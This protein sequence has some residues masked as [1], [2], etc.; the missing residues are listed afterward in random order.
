MVSNT[1]GA[2]LQ[3]V[4]QQPPAIRPEGKVTEQVNLISDVVQGLTSRPALVDHALITD[5]P[6]GL[7]FFDTEIGST[8]FLVGHKAGYLNVWELDGTSY[9]VTYED[10]DA[11]AYLGADVRGYVY[12]D[13][14]YVTDRDTTVAVDPTP[15]TD[16]ISPFTGVAL[17]LGGIYSRTY[18][19]TIRYADDTTAVGSYTT[20]DGTGTGDA[21]NTASPAIMD[22]IHTAI[23]AE[24]GWKSGSAATLHEGY[25]LFK[26][27]STFTLEVTDGDADVSIR[28]HTDRVDNVAGLSAIAPHG[29]LV[30]V[31]GSDEGTADDYWLR[32]N[33]DSTDTVGAGWP[34]A[35]VW[36]EWF[37]VSEPASFDLT[38]MPHVLRKDGDAFVLERG[39]WFARRTGDAETNPFPDFV[40][41]SIRDIGGFQSRLVFAAGPWACMTRTNEGEDFF[42]KSALT[43]LAD[44]P[45]GMSSTKE[46]SVRLDWIIPFDRDLVF[47][48]DP[49]AGQFIVAG[50]DKLTPSNASIVQ[51][52]AFEMRGGAKPVQTGRTIVFPYKAGTFSGIKE[53]YTNDDVTTNGAQTLTETLDRYIVGLVDHMACST[54]LSTILF[55]TD[56]TDA[57]STLWVYKYLWQGSD[58]V[59]SSWC[60]WE[61]PA[62][63]V[64]FFF[65]GSRVF[66]VLYH[67]DTNDYSFN[68]LDLDIPN[69]AVT[70]YPVCLDRRRDVVVGAGTV[71]LPFPNAR[72]AQS[73]DCLNIGSEAEADQTE[74]GADWVY[75][76]DTTLI[77]NGSTLI[78]G[79]KYKRYVEPTMP[80]L[81]DRNGA[82]VSQAHVVIGAFYI[83]YENVGALDT[84]MSSPYRDD[85]EY[86]VNFFEL[87][88]DPLISGVGMRSGTLEV[89]WGERADWS[90]LRIQS[91]DIRPTTILEVEW[92]GQPYRR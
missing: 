63:V 71:T 68:S 89:P 54:N 60:K 61:M 88:D 86:S 44:D 36:E 91:D 72:F 14:L 57:A 17:C 28:Q 16:S 1:L 78:A 12:D 38:T 59:Q 34:S 30:R 40:G 79:Q 43:E 80:F 29:T 73:T 58:K 10:A 66:V 2:L 23:I 41:H 69:D 47:M 70:G 67:S 22:A 6:S 37:D 85:Q 8:R 24:D 35:G 90:T 26:H 15:T 31:T 77:P 33:S 32:F 64:H 92:S 3:G 5:A 18:K 87:A 27:T 52:T 74:D 50:G 62:D 13:K 9:D 42:K 56:D 19:V 76:F 46:G 51:T 39:E 65:E 21:D 81:R 48:S 4:S 45:I 49:G 53:F 11:E 84:L 25:I 83:E 82:V 55:K 7:S 75:T 20:P